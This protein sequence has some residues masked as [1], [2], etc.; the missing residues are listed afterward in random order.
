MLLSAQINRD[1]SLDELHQTVEM[2]SQLFGG[3]PFEN[4]D[5]SVD[6][7]IRFAKTNNNIPVGLNPYELHTAIIGESGTGKTIMMLYCLGLQAMMK[8]ITCW[9]FVKARDAERLSKITKNILINDFDGQTKMNLLN[10]PPNYS[11]YGWK[12]YLWDIWTQAH[13]L[14]DGS[15]N[16][17]LEHSFDLEKKY[18]E[19]GVR[20]SFFELFDFVKSKKFPGFSR[21]AR[22]R[23]SVLNR[24]GGILKSSLRHSFDC[25]KGHL[26][27]LINQNVVFNIK[28]LTSQDQ[29][30]IVNAL[31]AWLY[32]FKESNPSNSMHFIFIDDA[33]LLANRNFERMDRVPFI[34][35]LLTEVRKLNIRLI[36]SVQ[37]PSLISKGFLG[38]SA[39]KILFNIPNAQ[40]VN[41]I[42]DIM[43]VYGKEKRE[44]ACRLD[45]SKREMLVKF[46]DRYTEPFIAS[47]PEIP[48]MNQLDSLHL[49]NQ[50]K[51]QHNESIIQGFSKVIPRKPYFEAVKVKTD[52]QQA[53]KI[54]RVKDLLIDI[55]NRFEVASTKRAKDLNLSAGESNRLYGYIEKE[56]FVEV[57]SL[58]LTGKKGG[59]SKFHVLTKKGAKIINKPPVRNYSGGTGSKHNFIQRYLKKYLPNVG[60]KDIE[61]EKDLG[62]KKIDLFCRYQELKVAIEI[63]VSTI[64]TEYLNVQKDFDK[65]DYLIIACPDKKTMQS[66]EKVIF[67]KVERHSKITICVVS[68]LLD[69]SFIEE[70]VSNRQGDLFE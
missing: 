52:R 15:K 12:A 57:V 33:L 38:T 43:G 8:G 29:V 17:L 49:T 20:P 22:Y 64:Q 36:S 35:L 19:F 11:E 39:L 2:A 32:C 41:Y 62:G 6:G 56:M 30:F 53:Q 59:L 68:R 65:C 9:Y 28:S 5:A 4:P 27:N 10:A 54:D 51:W 70:L 48:F 58:N 37:I 34:S 3:S 42:L 1:S 18:E 26:S 46:S 60:F 47:V 50:E 25:S 16:F 14:Y 55:Y 40:E 21:D 45:K 31:I 69:S 7:L 13:S 66:L 67:K 23:E 24:F 63:C 44:Y 61:I